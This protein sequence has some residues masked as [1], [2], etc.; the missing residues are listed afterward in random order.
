[1]AYQR[2]CKQGTTWM[3][4]LYGRKPKFMTSAMARL[5]YELMIEQSRQEQ[6]ADAKARNT[7][8]DPDV[9]LKVT[10]GSGYGYLRTGKIKVKF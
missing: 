2:A 8:F 7:H 5:T 9:A 4:E 3:E 10:G 1:M 6:I